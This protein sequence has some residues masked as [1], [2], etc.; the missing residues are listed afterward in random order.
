M[1]KVGGCVYQEVFKKQLLMIKLWLL[2]QNRGF[3]TLN[4]K[5]LDFICYLSWIRFCIIKLFMNHQSSKRVRD[6][7]TYYKG[8][9]E[10]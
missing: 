5:Q 1:A 6:A 4:K 10:Q 7:I 8:H 3:E 2:F 9:Y